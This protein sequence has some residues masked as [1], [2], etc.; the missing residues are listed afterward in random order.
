VFTS[1]RK[2]PRHSPASGHYR[3]AAA[4]AANPWHRP[5]RPRSRSTAFAVHPNHT[6]ISAT[7]K[8]GA[9]R[10]NA[11]AVPAHRAPRPPLGQVEVAGLPRPCPQ[12]QRAGRIA[13][14]AIAPRHCRGTQAERRRYAAGDPRLTVLRAPSRL[15]LFSRTLPPAIFFPA[16]NKI[17]NSWTNDPAALSAL[18]IFRW[19]EP[20]RAALER[21]PTAERSTAAAASR[22][23]PDDRSGG[24]SAGT[25]G[26]ARGRA[27]RAWRPAHRALTDSQPASACEAEPDGPIEPDREP[28]GRVPGPI[29]HVPLQERSGFGH[30]GRQL[31]Q[32]L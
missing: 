2:G 7:T 10:D 24:A 17:H 23:W 30:P 22:P 15:S 11:E 26:L 19:V 28:R 16:V 1:H 6:T 14:Q 8:P 32:S 27:P 31:T 3:N 21:A 29:A 9:G 5:R 25:R 20:R 4:G 18:A 13:A 12:R